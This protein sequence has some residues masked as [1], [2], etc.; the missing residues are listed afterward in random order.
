MPFPASLT[1]ITVNVRADLLPDGGSAGSVRLY[2]DGVPLTGPAAD[3]IVAYVDETATFDAAGTATLQVP[4]TNA[5]G[6]TPQDFAYRV[7]LRSGSRVRRG[8][9]QLDRATATVNLADL[10]QWDGAATAGTTYATLAQLT[11][12]ATDLDAAE[13]ATTAL[14]A[15]VSVLEDRQRPLTAA[16]TVLPRAEVTGAQPLATGTLFATHFTA[17]RTATVASLRTYTGG[18]STVGVGATHAWI[19]ILAWDG[20]DYTPITQS[21]DDPTRWAAEFATYNTMLMDPFAMVEGTEYAMYVLWIGSGQAPSLP[22]G[23]IWYADSQL[24][25]R[26]CSLLNNQTQQP[27]APISGAFFGPDSRR[28]Q[29]HLV[30]A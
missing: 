15:R 6:W 10:I 19:G 24:E 8:T 29:A 2:Y 4:A 18:A 13:A 1:L 5:V 25:P 9:V 21:V 3:S 12:V 11:A 14:A 17:D 27:A 22:G 26:M 30:P 23:Q 7:T 16:A 20:V 28:F